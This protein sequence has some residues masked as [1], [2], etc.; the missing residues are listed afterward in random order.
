LRW[1]T[2]YAAT[3]WPAD[4]AAGRRPSGTRGYLFDFLAA[5][6]AYQR[7]TASQLLAEVRATNSKDMTRAAA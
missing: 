3:R 4:H 1:L 7:G 5:G 6:E 2:D